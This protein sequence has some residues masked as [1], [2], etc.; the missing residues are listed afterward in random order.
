[1]KTEKILY[2]IT[3]SNWGG[4]QA[5]V[6][7]LATE[8]MRLG[9]TVTVALGGTGK[10]DAVPGELS[11]R[12]TD[13]GIRTLVVPSL[14]RD[15]SLINDMRAF[16]ELLRIIKKERPTVVH[17]NSSKA[18]GISALAGRVA[19][20]TRII[21][22]AHGLPHEEQRSFFSRA[23]IWLA[24][25]ATVLLST[26]T[27]VLSQ[28]Q[29]SATPALF[30]R[31][32]R[33]MCIPNGIAP[34]ELV[35]RAQA[36]GRCIAQAPE[37]AQY[38]RWI[39]ST[40]E[41]NRNKS[42]DVLIDAFARVCHTEPNVA[43][44]L[45]NEGDRH[46]A[47]EEQALRA[48]LQNRVFFLGLIPNVRTL[49]SVADIFVLSSQKEGF[50]FALLEAGIAKCPVIATS[51]GGIPELIN[52]NENG[53]LVTPGD[54][55]ELSNALTDLLTHTQRAKTFGEALSKRIRDKF[56][57]EEMTARTFA[58]YTNDER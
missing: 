53:I 37:L 3:K 50:P 22:T 18:G 32:R 17:V 29:F 11:K 38:S 58:L 55:A 45:F 5:Y 33:L 54:T 47:L 9:A 25:Y 52:T 19:G 14:M 48:G 23:L 20:K 42:I 41:L 35:G 40:G 28:R 12:L 21:F 39:V 36:R 49:L 56:S 15:M 10:K 51:V 44:V 46:G 6:Y 2:V 34:Y 1:M 26:K 13:A 27:I 7:T 30:V 57:R 31:T 4:A 16:M 8:A 24:T 43:L